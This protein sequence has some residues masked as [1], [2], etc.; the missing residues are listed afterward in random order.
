MSQTPITDPAI[1]PAN[2]SPERTSEWLYNEIMRFVQPDLM[3]DHLPLLDLKYAGENAFEKAARL[4]SYEEA[5]R[6][7]DEISVTATQPLVEEGRKE[8]HRHR[9]ALLE[10]ERAE[11]VVQLQSLEQSF[12]SIL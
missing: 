10:D 5:F 8:M 2:P 1:V 7:F 11:N 12:H 9:Q 4:F 6:V 3:T